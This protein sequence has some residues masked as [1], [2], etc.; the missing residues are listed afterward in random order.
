MIAGGE[1]VNV[2]K[3]MHSLTAR[4]AAEPAKT[5][6]SARGLTGCVEMSPLTGFCAPINFC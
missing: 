4:N 5:K 1:I 3:G 2:L 6:I